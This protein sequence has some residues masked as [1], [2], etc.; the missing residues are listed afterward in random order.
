MQLQLITDTPASNETVKK[1]SKRKILLQETMHVR[2][3]YAKC[4]NFSVTLYLF[5]IVHRNLYQDHWV[6]RVSNLKVISERFPFILVIWFVPKQLHKDY[7]Y[8]H[9]NSLHKQHN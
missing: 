3:I 4:D 9:I 1:F 2:A 7:D 8:T 6:C 5:L